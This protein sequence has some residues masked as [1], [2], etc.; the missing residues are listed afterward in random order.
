MV[1]RWCPGSTT[2]KLSVTRPS[3]PVVPRTS[4]HHKD[5][6][7]SGAPVKPSVKLSERCAS[8]GASTFTRVKCEGQKDPNK[9]ANRKNANAG[10]TSKPEF[11]GILCE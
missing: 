11:V 9:A 3:A 1:Q 4:I 10:T 5:A 7:A 6:A 2:R 8:M